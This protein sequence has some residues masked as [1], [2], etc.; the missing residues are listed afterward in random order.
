MTTIA[1][2][3]GLPDALARVI[4]ARGVPPE[5]AGLYLSPRLRDVFPDP[6]ALADMDKAAALIWD[7]VEA[8]RRI[9]VFADYDV[10]GATSAAQLVRWLRHVGQDADI[11]IPDRIEEGYG[12]SAKASRPCANAAPNSW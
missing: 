1:R 4:A 2:Q 5:T 6:S 8:G 7:A 11:Y 12:P 9:A 3:H 10:D